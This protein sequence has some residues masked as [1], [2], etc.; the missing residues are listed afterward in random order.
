MPREPPE[1]CERHLRRRERP[2]SRKTSPAT[3]GDA[4]GKSRLPFL[5]VARRRR[6][7]LRWSKPCRRTIAAYRVRMCSR[8]PPRTLAAFRPFLLTTVRDEEPPVVRRATMVAVLNGPVFAAGMQAAP[9]AKPDDGRLGVLVIRAMPKPRLLALL[10]QV[11]AGRHAGH[12]AVEQFTA[13]TLTLTADPPQPRNLDGDVPA[14]DPPAGPV[15]IAVRPALLT[16]PAP[17]P[18]PARRACP[19]TSGGYN[20]SL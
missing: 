12:G 18:F 8:R 3:D 14:S 11:M 9:D 1:A 7:A 13:R 10:P 15:E 19:R 5:E 4:R 17:D 20:A 2:L 6:G 16:V